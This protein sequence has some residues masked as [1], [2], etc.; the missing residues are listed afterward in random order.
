[1]GNAIVFVVLY[2]V[3]RAEGGGNHNSTYLHSASFRMLFLRDESKV[4]RHGI[5]L[6]LMTVCVCKSFPVR[7]LP[8]TRNAGTVTTGCNGFW[9][10]II[11]DVWLI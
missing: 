7:M 10:S 9:Y 8:T 4:T 5:A 6:Q 3:F 2:F 1:M 11:A